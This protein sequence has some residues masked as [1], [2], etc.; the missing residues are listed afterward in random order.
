MS[1]G[2]ISCGKSWVKAPVSAPKESTPNAVAEA[3][4]G[5]LWSGGMYYSGGKDLTLTLRW[6]GKEWTRVTSPA[7]S[8]QIEGMGFASAKY[9]WAVGEANPYS[10]NSRTYILHWNGSKWS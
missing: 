2:K 9:G 6:N 4:G 8:A 3:P 1:F 7:T 5:T 10:G